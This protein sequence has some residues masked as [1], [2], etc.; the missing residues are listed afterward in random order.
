MRASIEAVS[1][2]IGQIYDAAYHRQALTSVMAD[3]ARLFS[4]S[5]ACLL[6]MGADEESFQAV[7]SAD[8]VDEF[9]RLGVDTLRNDRLLRAMQALPVGIVTP[10]GQLIDESSFRRGEV[11]ESFFRPRDM[12]LGWTCKLRLSGKV[13]WFV[14]IQRSARQGPL[15][16]AEL[17]LLREIVP[18]FKRATEISQE[19]DDVAGIADGVSGLS[20]GMLLVDADCSVQRMNA[21][22]AALL[23]RAD[24]PVR[25]TNR[26]LVCADPQDTKR[27][28]RLVIDCCALDA[29]AILGP[30]GS[31][32]VTSRTEP[33]APPLILSVSPY[34]G[35]RPF[36]LGPARRAVI[37]VHEVSSPR[38][39][40]FEAQL[41]ALFGLTAAETKIAVSLAAGLTL[42]EAS[43]RS[44]IR[45]NT[46]RWYLEE[47]FRKT[48]TNRQGKLIALLIGLQS[49]RLR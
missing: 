25:L 11:W 47:I 15:T 33:P 38:S 1:R 49:V 42:K 48:S 23:E 20:L 44:A 31:M 43:E 16:D 24:S 14:D 45:I 36:E 19:L 5:R 3:L 7:A 41:R 2:L 37:L 6:R 29:G 40:D 8:D 27:L 39:V 46:A 13:S 32:L 21:T 10:R 26:E 17:G 30:G 18:H 12:E 9:I 35:S 28:R 34:L 4:G 22:V